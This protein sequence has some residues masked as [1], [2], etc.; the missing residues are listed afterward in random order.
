[1]D[2]VQLVAVGVADVEEG[3]GG[4]GRH[5]GVDA[6]GAE[7]ADGAP[8]AVF[9]LGA[10]DAGEGGGEVVGLAE[11]VEAGL[12]SHRS[13]TSRHVSTLT[14]GGTKTVGTTAGTTTSTTALPTSTGIPRCS[15]PTPG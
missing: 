8:P 3:L 12:G 9:T 4:G 13:G 6:P 11:G 15:W 5:L 7:P 2:D 14:A 10:D 1:V